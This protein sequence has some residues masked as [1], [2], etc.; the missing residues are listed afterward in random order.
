MLDQPVSAQ[1]NY[2]CMGFEACFLVFKVEVMQVR[3]KVREAGRLCCFRHVRLPI[4]SEVCRIVV[5][6]L[7]NM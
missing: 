5:H 2:A 3:F 1:G 4:T 6:H 7:C